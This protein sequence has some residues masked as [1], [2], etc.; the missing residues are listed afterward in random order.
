MY[1]REQPRHSDRAYPSDSRRRR[2]RRQARVSGGVAFL[3]RNSWA[4]RLIGS[5]LE[6][7]GR[8]IVR[9]RKRLI[10]S[11][12][13]R[14]HARATSATA[15]TRVGRTPRAIGTGQGRVGSAK[16]PPGRRYCQTLYGTRAG[17]FGSHSRRQHRVDAG[18]RTFPIS[19]GIQIQHLCHVVDPPGH[20]TRRGRP[21]PDH[22]GS[23]SYDRSV[24]T[25]DQDLPSFGATTGSRAQSRGNCPGVGHQ[26]RTGAAHDAGVFGTDFF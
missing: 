16:P 12:T 7:G 26:P 1:R 21:V 17:V 5:G 11:W 25:H 13:Q 6:R 10:R 22:S 4:E 2:S 18:G 19:E 20:F 8:T 24:A 9:S 3:D 14:P 23:G 15:S